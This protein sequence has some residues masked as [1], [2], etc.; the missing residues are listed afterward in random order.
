MMQ[1][2]GS[3]RAFGAAVEMQ[4]GWFFLQRFA[5]GGKN[6]TKKRGLSL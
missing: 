5:A 3:P 2:R 4:Q 6:E 1:D